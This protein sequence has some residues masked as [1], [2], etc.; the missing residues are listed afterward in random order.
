MYYSEAEER[1]LLQKYQRIYAEINLDA[2]LH[3]ME[4]MKGI[5]VPGTKFLGVVKADA[6][7][8]GSVP[9]ARKLEPYEYIFGFGVATAEEAHMLREGGIRKPVLIL[10]YSFPEEYEMLA[11]EEI[12]IA[13]FRKDMIAPLGEAARKTGKTVKVHVKVDTGMNRIGITPDREGLSFVKE[14]AGQKGV[15]IEGIFTHFAR[16]DEPDKTKTAE[17]LRTFRQFIHMIKEEL[18]LEIPLKHCANS[19]GI[20]EMPEADM[21][22]GRAG[23][24]MYGL[25]PSG[26][27]ARKVPL[28]PALALYSHVVYVKTIDKGQSV[29]Y[30]GTF[31]AEKTMRVATIPVG[32]GDG[33][34]RELSNK[35]YVLLHGRRAPILGRICMDQFMADVSEIPEAAEGSRAVLLGQDGDEAISAEALGEVSGRF[36]YELICGIGK[37]VPRI[38]REKGRILK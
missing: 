30:G 35:G 13:A 3:N 27:A 1:E 5:S 22:M 7:G 28:I 2:I 9:I 15:V 32:Y 12:R 17:Q 33:Y 21:D 14:L 6:Y 10:G 4:Y 37:R 29:S 8:H 11:A 18:S 16:A 31:T 34:P 23:I 25:S 20:L 26:E 36:H 19:A 38:Y 24:A